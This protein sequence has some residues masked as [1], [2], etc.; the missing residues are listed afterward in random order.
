MTGLPLRPTDYGAECSS[1]VALIS[2]P[3]LE[4][5]PKNHLDSDITPIL[6]ISIIFQTFLLRLG[7]RRR[8]GRAWR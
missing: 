1:L 5:V 7:L 2:A 3:H 4:H 8:A 6:S